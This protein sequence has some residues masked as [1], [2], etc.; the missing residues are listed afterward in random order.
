[1]FANPGAQYVF[2]SVRTF[3]DISPRKVL[4]K[5][6]LH[7]SNFLKLDSKFLIKYLRYGNWQSSFLFL[8]ML[9]CWWVQNFLSPNVGNIR[10][11]CGDMSD[12]EYFWQREALNGPLL[13]AHYSWDCAHN[14]HDNVVTHSS[15]DNLSTSVP[16][17]NAA[18]AIFPNFP[19]GS[20]QRSLGRELS[21]F[22]CDSGTSAIWWKLLCTKW[23]HLIKNSAWKTD[24]E[25]LLNWLLDF[26]LETLLNFFNSPFIIQNGVH[27][28][29][30]FVERKF[31]K[32]LHD[33][34][35]S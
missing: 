26:D 16:N 1:M 3:T 21:I 20:S 29:R 35:E 15:T 2:I 33:L 13:A 30:N 10:R 18:F 24:I 14:A 11:W 32:A 7:Q 8:T 22:F 31:Q 9:V 27:C 28:E 5:K 23:C 19:E 6:R 17:Q 4:K 25:L 12:K 34:L